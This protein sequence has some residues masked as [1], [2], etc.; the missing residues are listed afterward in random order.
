MILGLI[1]LSIVSFAI[2]A[3][4][5][6]NIII[7]IYLIITKQI[8]FTDAKEPLFFWGLVCISAI[9]II[10]IMIYALYVNIILGG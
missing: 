1:L 9:G 10:S 4:S 5:I 8:S 3:N 7:D 2:L 6:Y